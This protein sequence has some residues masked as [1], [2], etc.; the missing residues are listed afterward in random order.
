MDNITTQI[1]DI[2]NA[3]NSAYV[4]LYNA[5]TTFNFSTSGVD[6]FR[7]LI[8]Q[9]NMVA[10]DLDVLANRLLSVMRSQCKE[11]GLPCANLIDAINSAPSLETASQAACDTI[12]NSLQQ[13][14][15]S[16]LV[17]EQAISVLKDDIKAELGRV[18]KGA[19]SLRSYM[20]PDN[21]GSCFVN[22]I[23]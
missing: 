10:E 15:D 14:V 12:K 18:R 22:K 6:G 1:I 23:R 21:L 19:R 3:I 9:R 20:T 2:L 4:A 11:K 7:N 5:N 16:D 13:L 17:I 8:E